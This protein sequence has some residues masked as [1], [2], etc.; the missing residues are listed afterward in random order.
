MVFAN[1]PGPRTTGSDT[2]VATRIPPMNG[3]TEANAVGPSNH[4]CLW[5]M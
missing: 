3:R 2:D 5:T 4:G 1:A